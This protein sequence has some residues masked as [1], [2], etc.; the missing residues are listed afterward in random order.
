M[1]EIVKQWVGHM[2]NVFYYCRD[3]KVE[4]PNEKTCTNVTAPQVPAASV[5]PTLYAWWKI[6]YVNVGQMYK[7]NKI[8]P[9]LTLGTSYMVRSV[10][11]LQKG[12]EIETD[13]G[14]RLVN[15]S[16]LLRFFIPA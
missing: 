8:H 4:C 2:D 12:I 7:A 5:P 10:D 9:I 3:H 16:E 11:R 15:E 1:C 13:F 14:P 6:E